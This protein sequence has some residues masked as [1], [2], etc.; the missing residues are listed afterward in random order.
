MSVNAIHL[1]VPG[2][3]L[4]S[5]T[6]GVRIRVS[7]LLELGRVSRNFIYFLEIR[8]IVRSPISGAIKY[9]GLIL[10]LDH[11]RNLFKYPESVGLKWFA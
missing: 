9:V 2:E 6:L 8:D 4:S 5:G 1:A 7:V 11:S 3:N 10:K